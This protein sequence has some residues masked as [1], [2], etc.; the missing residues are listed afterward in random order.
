MRTNK[1]LSSYSNYKRRDPENFIETN[2]LI[3]VNKDHQKKRSDKHQA[4]YVPEIYNFSY[5]QIEHCNRPTSG[6]NRNGADV[7][8]GGGRDGVMMMM[9]DDEENDH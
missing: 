4:D 6:K 1:I 8:D 2:P 7:S 9:M 5:H 3:L